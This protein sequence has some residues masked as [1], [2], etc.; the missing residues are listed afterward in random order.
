MTSVDVSRGTRNALLGVPREHV[1]QAA[2]S[3]SSIDLA[4]LEDAGGNAFA[5]IDQEHGWLLVL[6]DDNVI[7]IPAYLVVLDP[8]CAP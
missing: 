7:P 5:G 8:G 6:Y 2:T 3:G 4:T 1:W